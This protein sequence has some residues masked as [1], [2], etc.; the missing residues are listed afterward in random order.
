MLTRFMGVVTAIGAAEHH[1]MAGRPVHG[2]LLR[3]EVMR[4]PQL[5]CCLAW[6]YSNSAMSQ[7]RL[8]SRVG[9]S[10]CARSA[11]IRRTRCFQA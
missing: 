9:C 5:C 11:C 1:F 10:S 8:T 7:G 6:L 4:D 2:K 3:C